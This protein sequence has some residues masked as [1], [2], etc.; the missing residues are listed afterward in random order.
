MV[1]EKLKLMVLAGGPDREREV[2]LVSGAA[3]AKALRQVGHDVIERDIMP[4]HLHALDEFQ[5]WGGQAIFPALHGRW[6]EGG[7]LQQILDERSLP[8][9]G[10][11]AAAAR[12]CMDKHQAKLAVKRVPIPT[13]RFELVTAEQPHSLTAPLVVKAPHEGSTIGLEMCFTDDAVAAARQTLHRQY[14]TL[15]I[16]QYVKGRELT[17]GIIDSSEQEGGQCTA[18]PPIHIVP[19]A[20]HYDYQAKYVRDDT[21]Y[22]FDIDLPSATIEQVRDLAVR[23][24]QTLGARH[25]SRV[26]FMVDE[27]GQPWFIEINTMP[28]FTSHSLLPMAAKRSGMTMEQLVDRLVRLAVTSASAAATAGR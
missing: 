18:L 6:G 13:P 15:L 12:L 8:Y 26:D 17:V 3:V 22:L 14:P 5:A 20:G 21:Q 24:H 25:L 19:A 7:A 11:R 4:D 9:V 1:A 2:S 16:E 10:C 23:A 28:G 27:Q